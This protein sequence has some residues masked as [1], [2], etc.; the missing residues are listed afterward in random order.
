M[1]IERALLHC[2]LPPVVLVANADAYTG[3]GWRG[4]LDFAT[5]QSSGAF[6]GVDDAVECRSYGNGEVC[7]RLLEIGLR[8]E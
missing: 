5:W 1:R 2:S 6:D 8:A 7:R 3:T 4:R